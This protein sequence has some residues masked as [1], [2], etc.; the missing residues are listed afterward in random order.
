MV[1]RFF[2]LPPLLSDILDR[3]EDMVVVMVVTRYHP[4]DMGL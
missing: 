3:S 1:G 2:R 4:S